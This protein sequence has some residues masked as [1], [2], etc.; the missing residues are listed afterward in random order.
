MGTC[1]FFY[2]LLFTDKKGIGTIY[3]VWKLGIGRVKII[4]KCKTHTKRLLHSD[5]AEEYRS[6]YISVGRL[7]VI[8][9]SEGKIPIGY[10]RHEIHSSMEKKKILWICTT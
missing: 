2:V 10:I 1:F 5:V 8:I 4:Q 3:S 6:I 9:V 7:N